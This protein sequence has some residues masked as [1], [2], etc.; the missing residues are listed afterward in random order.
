[1]SERADYIHDKIK[2]KMRK[3]DRMKKPRSRV[4]FLKDELPQVTK[5][6]M[7]WFT[8]LSDVKH[9]VQI[10]SDGT[11]SKLEYMTMYPFKVDSIGVGEFIGPINI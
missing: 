8:D 6:G 5:P 7:Y 11:A 10:M 2:R 3:E 9:L 4:S 1:M